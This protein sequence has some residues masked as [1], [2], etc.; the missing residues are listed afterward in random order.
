MRVIPTKIH[1]LLDYIGAVVGSLAIL[2]NLVT[3]YEWGAVKA[4][5]VSTHLTLDLVSGILLAL[6]PW[7]FGFSKYIYVP[8][9]SLGV[10]EILVTLLTKPM[11]NESDGDKLMKRRGSFVRRKFL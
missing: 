3:N 2:Y 4:I 10:L 8:H 9:L 6:S 11:H 7:L 5:S 1:G